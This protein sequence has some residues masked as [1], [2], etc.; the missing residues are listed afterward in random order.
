MSHPG[1]FQPAQCAFGIFPLVPAHN[2]PW[3]S[4]SSHGIDWVGYLNGAL[5]C[6]FNQIGLDVYRP[7]SYLWPTTNAV[8]NLQAF[9]GL[10]VDGVCGPQTWAVVQW[11]V[12][13]F[14]T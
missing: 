10:H 2:C 14:P 9:F 3:L 4:Y 7:Y 1:G 6:H 11:G 12:A 5:Q 8:S 13:G